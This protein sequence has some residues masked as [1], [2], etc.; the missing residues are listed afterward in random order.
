MKKLILLINIIFALLSPFS[1]SGEK[2]VLPRGQASEKNGI[3]LYPNALSREG[4][5]SSESG[6]EVAESELSSLYERFLET[7]PEG[8][9]ESF[10]SPEGFPG[11]EDVL[12]LL[13]EPLKEAIADISGSLAAVIA[14]AVIFALS[15]LFIADSGELGSAVRSAL[16]AVLALPAIGSAASLIGVCRDGISSGSA[17]FAELIP[18][19]TAALAM[20]GGAS[21]AAASAS[22]MSLALGAVS[23]VLLNNL[24][25]VFGLIFAL[26]VIGN[27]DKGQRV[28]GFSR[29]ARNLFGFFLGAA[30]LILGGVIALQSTIAVSRDSLALRGAKYAIS[31]MIPIVGGAV[32]GALSTLISGL[33][34]L[35]GYIGAVS[36]LALAVSMAAPLVSLLIYKLSLGI[37]ASI[38]SYTGAAFGEKFFKSL[39]SAVDCLIAVVS[40]SLVLYTLIIAVFMKSA[41]GVFGI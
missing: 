8:F 37:G 23:T 26:S 6:G 3:A 24:Y 29:S 41:G 11:I 22:G 10:A 27:I 30:T 16:S 18:I 1:A 32:S 28:A 31:G 25:P 17:F 9:T 36:V 34:V 19:L 7:L 39:G 40:S 38:C 12:S 14:A 20:G 4:G 35:S 5:D 15:E 2:E 21:S 33:K 13:G